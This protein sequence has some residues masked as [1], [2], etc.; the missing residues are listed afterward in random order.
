M[1]QL[2]GR[3]GKTNDWKLVYS[4]SYHNKTLAYARERKIKKWK[5]RRHLLNLISRGSEH[6]D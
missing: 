4:E 6:P 3:D 5:N 2:Y 1:A